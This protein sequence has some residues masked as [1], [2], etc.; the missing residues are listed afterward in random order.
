M[1]RPKLSLSQLFVVIMMIL[2]IVRCYEGGQQASEQK[3]A[4]ESIHPEFP[5]DDLHSDG[6]TAF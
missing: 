2:V 4:R 6:V 1:N 3:E 5:C